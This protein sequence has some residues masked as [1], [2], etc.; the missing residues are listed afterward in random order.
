MSEAWRHAEA[1]RKALRIRS[2]M[3]FGR[4]PTARTANT[5]SLNSPFL[6]QRAGAPGRW[7]NRSFASCCQWQVNV[8][9][10]VYKFAFLQKYDN[11]MSDA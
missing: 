11:D 5:V 9:P 1:D 2:G 10:N 3:N 6:R 7:W 8:T 4:E